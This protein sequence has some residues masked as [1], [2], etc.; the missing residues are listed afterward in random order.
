MWNKKFYWDMETQFIFYV[1]HQHRR[2]NIIT[3][4]SIVQYLQ[5]NES[6]PIPRIGH[7]PVLK[8]LH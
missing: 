1:Q 7:W 3:E 8:V 4:V 2:E 6:I 5:K